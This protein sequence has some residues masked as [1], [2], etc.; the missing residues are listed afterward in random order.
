M[1]LLLDTG[2]L[3]ML[4]HPRPATNPDVTT[5]LR[6][7][8]LGGGAVEIFVPEIA[9]CELR[10]KL[11]HNAARSGVRTTRSLRRLD[12]L[13]ALLD[14]LPLDTDTMR[15]AAQLWADARTAGQ[16]TADV[17]ALDGDVILAAQALAVDGVVVAEN[18]SHLAR[19]VP[20]LLG[21]DLPVGAT[22]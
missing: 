21:S 5:W 19:F 8:I 6:S 13:E 4:C 20:A 1:R 2:V 11:L 14:Y 9:D 18:V 7:Q 3:G 10:R 16:P 22:R 15:T 17:T 12:E